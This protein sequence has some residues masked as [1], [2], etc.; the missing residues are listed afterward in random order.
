MYISMKTTGGCSAI[1]EGFLHLLG[2][3]LLL[4]GDTAKAIE[5]AHRGLEI[6][7][8]RKMPN[9]FFT[10]GIAE[11]LIKAGKKKRERS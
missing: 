7:P 10:I 5:V 6:V 2:K 9:D 1:S 8:S 3:I 11:V 4:R